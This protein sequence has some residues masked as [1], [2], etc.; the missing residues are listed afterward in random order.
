MHNNCCFCSDSRF[1]LLEFLGLPSR[2]AVVYED[3]YFRVTPDIAPL[4]CGHLLI[5]SKKHIYCFG[6]A[7]S[8]VIESL[9][10]IK[11]HIKRELFNSDDVLFFEHGAVVEHTGGACIDHAHLHTLP[12]NGKIDMNYTDNFVKNS[13]FVPRAKVR[14]VGQETLKQFFVQKQPYIF[15]EIGKER[16]VYPVDTLPSQFFRLM[17][18]PYT[19][20][21]YN[22][23]I[24]YTTDES[25]QLFR[26]TLTFVKGKK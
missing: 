17:Y 26:D 3:E 22:W 21:N 4:V 5:M 1:E 16:W 13:G 9:E 6:E 15:Y 24:S 2:D 19:P 11:D 23:K 25:K 10:K 20:L 12:H 18:Q 7:D 14:V 8:M